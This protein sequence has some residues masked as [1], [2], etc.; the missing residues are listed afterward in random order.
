MWQ[1]L[2]KLKFIT[3]I[4]YESSHIANEHEYANINFDEGNDKLVEV[5][6]QNHKL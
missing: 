1:K 4:N 3:L 5:K 2:L 6:A